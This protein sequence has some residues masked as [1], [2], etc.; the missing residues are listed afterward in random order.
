MNFSVKFFLFQ[1]YYEFML[2][3]NLILCHLLSKLLALKKFTTR[4]RLIV[5]EALMQM[6]EIL[7][8]PLTNDHPSLLISAFVLKNSSFFTCFKT[9][10][11][12]G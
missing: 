9:P 8:A 11:L 2:H 6:F 4:T 7:R 3:L 12:S 10:A 5:V 1:S